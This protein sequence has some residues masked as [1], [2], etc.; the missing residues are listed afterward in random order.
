VYLIYADEKSEELQKYRI[1]NLNYL[2]NKT[3]DNL[4]KGICYYNIGNIL[5]TYKGSNIQK[6]V[7]YY[8]KSRKFD[9]NYENR[10]YW[11][12]EL[13][14]LMFEKKHYKISESFYRKSLQLKIS[15]AYTG[16]LRFEK[17]SSPKL[18]YLLIADCL[19]MQG[20]FIEA[21]KLFEEHYSETNLYYEYILKDMVC[22]HL[23]EMK[24]GNVILDKKKSLT[25]CEKILL[26]SKDEE[27][28]LLLK[29]AVKLDPL[30]SLAWFNLGIALNQTKE[31]EESL[32]CFIVSGVIVTGDKEAQFNALFI[33]LHQRNLERFQVLIHYIIEKHGKMIAN[34]FTDYIMKQNYTF[35]F[36]QQMLKAFTEFFEV[37]KNIKNNS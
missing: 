1:E 6:S 11:W 14:G 24:L 21:H 36:K 28:I 27:I 26:I 7:Q 3:N 20:K 15:S 37:H 9:P 32:V 29:K 31:F 16:V 8:F 17:K 10:H 23:I 35:D 12:Y 2:I 22:I 4:R 34:D 13:A 19:F 5:I 25:I 18:I 30:N 33:C